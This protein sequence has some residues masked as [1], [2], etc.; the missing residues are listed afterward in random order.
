[1]EN[2]LATNNDP[3]HSDRIAKIKRGLTLPGVT[4]IGGISRNDLAREL[5]EAELQLY[6]CDPVTWTEGF[7]CS[8]L[9]SCAAGALPILM[10][11]D[12][13]GQIY[14]TACP[15]AARGDL[16][17]WS[18]LALRA[19]TVPQWANRHRERARQLALSYAWPALA[20]KLEEAIH[21]HRKNA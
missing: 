7:S 2:F 16:A 1:L 21:A 18:S 4:V 5:A 6:P 9:E 10:D 14:G 19:L 15:T 8:T 12:A 3:R 11:S 17:Q 13:M 20:E